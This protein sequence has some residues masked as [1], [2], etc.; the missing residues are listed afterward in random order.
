MDVRTAA[1]RRASDILGG[2][3]QLRTY[4]GVSAIALTVWITGV[5][6][7][8]TDVFLRTVDVIVQHE[9]DELRPKKQK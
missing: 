7:P 8:P 2:Q 3:Q 4:L 9:L 6:E 5:E 1:I